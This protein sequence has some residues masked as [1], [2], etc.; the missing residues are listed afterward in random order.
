MIREKVEYGIIPTPCYP[1]SWYGGPVRRGHPLSNA[2]C[3][4]WRTKGAAIEFC[5]K[6]M[7]NT[8]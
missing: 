3:Y 2:T 8:C 1:A 5:D 7:Q 4:Y 6:M